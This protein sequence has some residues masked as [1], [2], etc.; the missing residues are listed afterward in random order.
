MTTQTIDGVSVNTLASVHFNG[1]C[2]SHGL[3]LPDGTKLS[4][5]VVLPAT[6]T[7]STGVAEIMECVGGFCEY[8]L[9]GSSEWLK[10]SAGEEFS[11]PAHSKFEIRIPEGG[12]PYHYICHYA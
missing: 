9:D 5:G 6:L 7:F 4:V 12:E 3:T 1:K 10:S 8:K 2:I 11:V